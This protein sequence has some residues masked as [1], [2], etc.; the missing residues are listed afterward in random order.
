MNAEIEQKIRNC[1]AAI[2]NKQPAEPLKYSMLPNHPFAEIATEILE[3]ESLSYLV[4]VDY[5]SS[6]IQTA[7][8]NSVI[9]CTVIEALKKTSASMA[10]LTRSEQTAEHRE[11]VRSSRTF[12]RNTAFNT[13][14]CLHITRVQT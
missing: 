4:T 14:W 7:K 9:R 8:L 3:F 5:Y 12:T 13:T 2:S 1:A 6:F 11:P 10:S